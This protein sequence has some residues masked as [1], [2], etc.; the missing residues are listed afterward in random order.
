MGE[1]LEACRAAAGGGAQLEW[2]DEAFLERHEV[3]PWK[4]LPLW[5]PESHTDG[6]GFLDVPLRRALANGL[7][8]R[9]LAE[10][11]ADT[12]AWNQARAANHEWKAGLAAD[13]ERS[14]L[15]AWDA[16]RPSGGTSQSR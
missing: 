8:L 10:T 3:A 16:Q 5:L 9:P 7:A 15:Q 13:R 12:L 6:S 1:F 4:E 2:V 14:L 11:I